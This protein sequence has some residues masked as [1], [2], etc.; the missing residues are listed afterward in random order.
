MATPLTKAKNRSSLSAL[1]DLAAKTPSKDD[2]DDWPEDDPEP[3]VPKGPG[4]I[5]S[6][7]S[8][9]VPDT[10]FLEQ[11]SQLQKAI[12]EN[13]TWPMF[14]DFTRV[15]NQTDSSPWFE[16]SAQVLFAQLSSSDILSSS[17]T[18]R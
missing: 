3:I 6:P 10:D 11:T 2:L 12:Q 17:H 7:S 5:S 16:L 8:N 4:S 15:S 14:L 13:C 18:E 1:K 9:Q